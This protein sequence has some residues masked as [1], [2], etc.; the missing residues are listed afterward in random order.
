MD[1]ESKLQCVEMFPNF[2]LGTSNLRLL[3]AGHGNL[4]FFLTHVTSVW[5]MN[6]KYF[7]F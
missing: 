1:Y 7:L 4:C 5:F 6:Q 2:S 3:V